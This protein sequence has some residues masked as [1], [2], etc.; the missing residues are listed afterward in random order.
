MQA[1]FI[2]YNYNS[3]L[4]LYFYPFPTAFQNPK[5]A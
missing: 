2:S 1:A 4:H 3:C 5:S